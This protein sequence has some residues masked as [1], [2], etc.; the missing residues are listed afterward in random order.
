[1]YDS[2]VALPP[3]ETDL[4]DTDVASSPSA[5]RPE[6]E[7]RELLPGQSIGRFVVERELGRGGMGVVFLADDPELGRK[8]AVKLLNHSV[9]GDQ[10]SIARERLIREA[11]A[12]AQ[13]AHPN[14]VTVYDVGTWEGQV[15]VAMEYIRGSSFRRWQLEHNPELPELLKAYSDAARGL[16]AAHLAGFVHRDFKPDNVLYGDDGIVRVLDF[17]IATAASSDFEGTPAP[18]DTTPSVDTSE[19]E[20]LTR[21]GAL[22]GTPAYM[23][24]EQLQ[25]QPVDSRSD[26]FSWCVSLFEAVYGQRPF[27]GSN[28]AALVLNIVRGNM[29]APAPELI[30]PIPRHVDDAIRKGLSTDPEDRFEDMEDLLSALAGSKQGL[31]RRL[32]VITAGLALATIGVFAF[33][34]QSPES[35]PPRDLAAAGA[36]SASE[37]K[38]ATHRRPPGV[39]LPRGPGES[40]PTP[41]A[42]VWISSDHM[43][44]TR[45]EDQAPAAVVQLEKGKLPDS[46]LKDRLVVPLHKALSPADGETAPKRH[47]SLTIFSDSSVPWSTLTSAMYSSARAGYGSFAIAVDVEGEARVIALSVPRFNPER[48]SMRLHATMQLWVSKELVQAGAEVARRDGV[49]PAESGNRFAIDL[50]H[51][52]CDIPFE[53]GADLSPLGRAYQQVCE[54]NRAPTPVS[55]SGAPGVTWGQ[56]AQTLAATL[57]GD[58]PCR[59]SVMMTMAGEFPMCDSATPVAW[60]LDQLEDGAAEDTR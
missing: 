29:Q 47:D 51:G 41:G 58:G 2:P 35:T 26:Q 34:T 4:F 3:T 52:R 8:V 1:V 18:S 50:G 44:A 14:V 37:N 12:M 43:Y 49:G 7:S 53:A 46:A 39:E 13:V 22:M 54:L 36:K 28:L 38:T 55:I 16:H 60:L 40:K 9:G 32:S 11:R 48:G 57:P 10:G 15:F 27:E 59:D 19:T 31:T 21:T 45:H 30:A 25:S 33:L 23:A 17:G 20:S 6:S 42:E 24:P 56:V 5:T